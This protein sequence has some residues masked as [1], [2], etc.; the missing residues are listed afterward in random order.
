VCI[1][2]EVPDGE[3]DTV[4]G[5]RPELGLVAGQYRGILTVSV[6]GAARAVAFDGAPSLNVA[7]P[8]GE[9]EIIG[10]QLELRRGERADAVLRFRLPAGWQQLRVEASARVPAM[11]WR[12]ADGRWRD[13]KSRVRQLD[14]GGTVAAPT[15]DG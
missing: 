8:D 4:T 2:N 10:Y 1:V 13:R 3:P 6:P 11:H 5:D 14:E 9:S 7:G 15:C 12:D